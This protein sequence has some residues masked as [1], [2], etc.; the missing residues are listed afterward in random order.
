MS[1]KPAFTFSAREKRGDKPCEDY[2]LLMK[3]AVARYGEEPQWT[4]P[5]A[6]A[7][8]KHRTAQVQLMLDAIEQVLPDMAAAIQYAVGLEKRIAEAN[9][10]LALIQ[11]SV[12]EI[13]DGKARG[14]D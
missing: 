6:S 13:V 5:V 9:F 11:Q 1:D 3:I 4:G 10:A 14:H 2:D 8:M 7:L 12:N